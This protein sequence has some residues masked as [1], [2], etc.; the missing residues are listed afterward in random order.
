MAPLTQTQL[1]IYLETS[2]SEGAQLYHNPWLIKLDG[3]SDSDLLA[4]AVAK[5]IAAHPGISARIVTDGDGIPGWAEGEQIAVERKSLPETEL[6]ETKQTLVTPFELDGG[7][8]SR[9]MVIETDGGNYLFVDFHHTLFDGGSFRVFLEDIGAAYAGEK[10]PDE[11][12]SLFSQAARE[13]EVRATPALTQAADAY[14]ILL[15]GAETGFD[16][17]PD[18]SESDGAYST[19][20]ISLDIDG[21]DYLTWCRHNDMPQSVR[22][23]SRRSVAP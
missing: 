9:V 5:A 22:H 6:L 18:K 3:V 7:P 13:V 21:D 12:I 17:L 2:Q 15:G 16:M 14:R 8:L 23:F 20:R 4:E 1:G 10:I 19:L 11:R